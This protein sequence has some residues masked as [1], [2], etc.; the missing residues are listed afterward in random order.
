MESGSFV[1]LRLPEATAV[2]ASNRVIQF[3][4]PDTEGCA[5]DLPEP[6][7]RFRGAGSA[8]QFDG[9]DSLVSSVRESKDDRRRLVR[10]R[11]SA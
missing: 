3:S 2:E 5:V 7:P 6:A 8:R 9:I 11:A 4:A 1:P 10:S